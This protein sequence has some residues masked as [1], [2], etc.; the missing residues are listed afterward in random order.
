ML[1]GLTKNRR[2]MQS[3]NTRLSPAGTFLCYSSLQIISF[4]T[5]RRGAVLLD[6]RTEAEP[7]TMQ[8][9]TNSLHPSH[10]HLVLSLSLLLD[11]DVIS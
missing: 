4:F 10:P 8:N 2:P 11:L 7:V 3:K 1:P 9:I 6:M 5:G